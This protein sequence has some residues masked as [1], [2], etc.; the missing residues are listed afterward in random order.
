MRLL[1]ITVVVGCGQM[2]NEKSEE[3]SELPI[4]T[5]VVELWSVVDWVQIQKHE[6]AYAV[7][8]GHSTDLTM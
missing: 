6:D 3:L 2:T 1:K 7:T 5:I 4:V 8:P